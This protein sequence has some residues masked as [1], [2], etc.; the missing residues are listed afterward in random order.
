MNETSSERKRKERIVNATTRPMD[1][2]D[3]KDLKSPN[4]SLVEKIN[5]EASEFEIEGFGTKR[6]LATMAGAPE[7][8][9]KKIFDNAIKAAMFKGVIVTLECL[10]RL[11]EKEKKHDV[12]S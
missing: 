6:L 3:D 4:R 8:L 5:E 2:L 11:D 10:D 7:E 9:Q 12:P 1:Q